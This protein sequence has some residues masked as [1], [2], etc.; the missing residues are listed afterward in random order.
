MY[1]YS[2]QGLY[3]VPAE[4]AGKELE[5]IRQKYGTLKAEDVV[6]ESKDPSS[7]LHSIFEWNNK[8]A[9]DA[10]RINQAKALIRSVIVTVEH[11]EVQCKVRAFVSVAEGPHDRASYVPIHEATSNDYA[12]KYL[13]NC[14]KHDMECFTAKY[15]TL[16]E[17]DGIIGQ[18]KLFL[19]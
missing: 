5:R 3:K 1:Q 18:M 2:I 16:S 12:K 4:D 19:E 8:K 7:L 15:R 13:M 17:L 11:K 9:G 6:T 14:A 10:W